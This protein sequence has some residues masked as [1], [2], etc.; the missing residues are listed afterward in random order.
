MENNL[1]KFIDEQCREFEKEFI[2]MLHFAET[3]GD[4]NE[5]ERTGLFLVKV[6]TSC[7][8]ATADATQE[9]IVEI[10]KSRLP[11][12]MTEKQMEEFHCEGSVLF[13]GEKLIS[14]IQ[15]KERLWMGEE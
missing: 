3:H 9:E 4:V 7:A 13:W 12:A 10:I 14:S 2:G 6:L 8:R 1:K 5:I 15:S 11:D